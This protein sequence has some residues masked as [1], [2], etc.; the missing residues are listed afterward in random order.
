[1]RSGIGAGSS[2]DQPVLVHAGEDLASASRVVSV[3]EVAA[4]ARDF[5]FL[6]RRLMVQPS[7]ACGDGP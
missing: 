4:L 7:A 5:A 6:A 1:V 2:T 3:I